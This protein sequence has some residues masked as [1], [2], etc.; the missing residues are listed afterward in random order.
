MTSV[1]IVD[2][3]KTAKFGAVCI[4]ARDVSLLIQIGILE[5]KGIKGGDNRF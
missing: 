2:V 1:L 5:D 3:I 4:A